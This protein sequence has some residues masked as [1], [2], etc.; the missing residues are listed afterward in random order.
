MASSH[1]KNLEKLCRICGEKLQKSKGAV[2]SKFQCLKWK[3]FLAE[4]FSI[5]VEKDLEE[6]HLQYFCH[7]C[8]THPKRRCCSSYMGDALW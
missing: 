7:A 1:Q 6:I 2:S 5:F 8:Y 4:K 3:E